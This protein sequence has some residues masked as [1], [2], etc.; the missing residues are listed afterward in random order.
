MRLT[1]ASGAVRIFVP[2]T[3]AGVA[4][5]RAAGEIGPVPLTAYAV[6]GMLRESFADGDEEELALVAT[7]AAAWRSLGL[8]ARA[9]FADGGAADGGAADGGVGADVAAGTRR[10]V[11]TADV[12]DAGVRPVPPDEPGAGDGAVVVAVAIPVEAVVS[13]LVD[14]AWLAPTVAAAL[15]AVA[16]GR[17]ADD[18]GDT[19]AL[20]ADP[21]LA[22]LDEV[23]ASPLL[24]FDA[25]ELPHLF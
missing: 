25:A 19:A 13:V 3:V 4:A 21:A 2:A 14:G 18:L 7:E 20:R 5:A 23:L 8:L 17:T 10:V 22:A 11:L 24:W 9:G 1:L 15:P 12:E 6:T 16:A